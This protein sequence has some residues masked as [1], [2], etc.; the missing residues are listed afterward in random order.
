VSSTLDLRL[1]LKIIVGRAVELSGTDGGSI[2]YYRKDTGR[3]ELGEMTG[4][5]AD[6]VKRIRNLD[7]ALGTTGFD[8]AIANRQ[9]LQ[10]PNGT[11]RASNPLRDAA[12]DTGLYAALIVPLLSAEG[13]LGALVLQRRQPGELPQAV[14]SVT[15]AFADQ[16]AIGLENARLFEEIAQKSR[17]LEIASQHKSQFVAN[18][19][20]ELR[21]P[22]AAM[23]GYA[24]LLQEGIAREI[25]ADPHAH[26][27]Q[28]QAPAG[29]D[30]YRP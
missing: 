7:I 13:P 14:V 15:Q 6:V 27:F 11:K 4:F 24:E 21:T 30:Q 18:M 9:P 23:L 22:L 17:E 26:P 3:F 5:D 16:S 19:S 28:R 8:G 10:V 1:V 12:L 2:F 20:H 25:A 29:S